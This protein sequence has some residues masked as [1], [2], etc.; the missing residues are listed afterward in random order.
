[1]KRKLI[2]IKAINQLM[3]MNSKLL[4]IQDDYKLPEQIET[5]IIQLHFQLTDIIKE[6]KNNKD[7]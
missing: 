7:Y 2:D 3:R 5:D 4:Q 6:L 1:M